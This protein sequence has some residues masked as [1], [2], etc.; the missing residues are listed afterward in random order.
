MFGAYVARGGLVCTE[1]NKAE[2]VCIKGN[3]FHRTAVLS[4]FPSAPDDFW[5]ATFAALPDVVDGRP[6]HCASPGL[7]NLL[8]WAAEIG[9]NLVATTASDTFILK[10]D[11][12]V[13]WGV[14]N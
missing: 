8:D 12:R 6:G 9:Y 1:E 5:L 2:T 10:K 13:A 11:C 3:D 14:N 7:A 4:Q